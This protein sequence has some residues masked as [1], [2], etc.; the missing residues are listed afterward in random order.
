MAVMRRQDKPKTPRKGGPGKEPPE[1]PC[2]NFEFSIEDWKDPEIIRK[3]QTRIGTV[4]TGS[5]Q[6]DRVCKA[7]VECKVGNTV[8]TDKNNNRIM[9][10]AAGVVVPPTQELE[11]RCNGTA[12]RRQTGFTIS[13]FFQAPPQRN[14]APRPPGVAGDDLII[15]GEIDL[16]FK[17]TQCATVP[18]NPW[19]MKLKIKECQLDVD[20]SNYDGDNKKN[21]AEKGANA[22]EKRKNMFDPAN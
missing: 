2:Q 7:T 19:R 21:S 16:E 4:P 18:A 5:S 11:A 6:P 12:T 1:C 17:L 22:G 9:P 15:N 8:F 14:P 13:W 20:E 10:V 3:V